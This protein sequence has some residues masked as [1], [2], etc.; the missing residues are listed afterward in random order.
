MQQ[1]HDDVLQKLVDAQKEVELKNTAM[2]VMEQ[3]FENEQSKVELLKETL[4][5]VYKR[6]SWVLVH[7]F[8]I[9]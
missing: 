3:K 1:K 9:D 6:V 5:M 2:I 7:L 4:S 8:W